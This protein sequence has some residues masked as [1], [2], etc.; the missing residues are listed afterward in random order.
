MTA[1]P[2]S[3]RLIGSLV[4]HFRID[5]MLGRGGMGI[6]YQA[7]DTRLNRLVAFGRLVRRDCSRTRSAK[8]FSKGS[9]CRI[10]PQPSEHLHDL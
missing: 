9:A 6:V 4:S 3:H 5:E 1:S 7:T 8:P 10:R 2:G